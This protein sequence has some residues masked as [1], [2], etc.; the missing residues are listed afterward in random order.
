M[1]R[2]TENSEKRLGTIHAGMGSVWHIKY[3]DLIFTDR[4]LIVARTGSNWPLI[5]GVL[6]FLLLMKRNKVSERLSSLPP[7]K[8]LTD[9]KDNFSIPYDEI[10]KV[11]LRKSWMMGNK[12]TVY[13]STRKYSFSL[14][15]KKTLLSGKQLL[16]EYEKLLRSALPGKL[17]EGGQK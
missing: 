17:I 3:C 6:A 4:R 15:G 2:V 5:L 8:V 13:R 10:N 11:E 7:D 1:S 14:F 16:D 12:L 9:S